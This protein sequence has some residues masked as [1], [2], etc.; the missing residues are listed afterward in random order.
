MK[1]FRVVKKGFF[2]GKLITNLKIP[3]IEIYDGN[4]N[5]RLPFGE[6]RLLFRILVKQNRIAVE[7]H[8][9][10][11]DGYGSSVFLNTLLVEYFKLKGISVIDW[12][13][14]FDV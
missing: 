12:N 9:I 3:E 5:Q 6:K 2:W 1:I 13:N 10:L 7:F 4:T 8:H 14:I 11:T